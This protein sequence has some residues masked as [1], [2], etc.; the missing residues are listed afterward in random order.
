TKDLN[1]PAGRIEQPEQHLDGG[2]FAGTIWAQQTEDLATAHL[3]INGINRPG[4]GPSPKILEDLGQAANDNHRLIGIGLAGRG[5]CNGRINLGTGRGHTAG[6]DA[7]AG[8][9][10]AA[11]VEPAPLSF[12]AW[13]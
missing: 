7:M 11:G 5:A 9:A 13:P 2:R 1:V 4:L 6:A 10:G 8:A 3:E 12:G